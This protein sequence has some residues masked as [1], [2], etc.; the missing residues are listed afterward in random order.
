MVSRPRWA[1]KRREEKDDSKFFPRA[2][3]IV[4]SESEESCG[5]VRY[6]F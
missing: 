4:R 5:I 2:T 3:R 1:S 6:N